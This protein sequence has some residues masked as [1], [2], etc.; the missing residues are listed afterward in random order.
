MPLDAHGITDAASSVFL[1]LYLSLSMAFFVVIGALKRGTS[2]I[3]YD[4]HDENVNA[5]RVAGFVLATPMIIGTIVVRSSIWA[6]A[7]T[8]PFWGAFLALI[9][10]LLLWIVIRA[11]TLGHDDPGDYTIESDRSEIDTRWEKQSKTRRLL[12]F[13]FNAWLAGLIVAIL[14]LKHLTHYTFF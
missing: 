4:T 10:L 8:F 5:A 12:S 11:L 2:I 7:I 9:V 14:W 3:P 1:M 6:L 13:E